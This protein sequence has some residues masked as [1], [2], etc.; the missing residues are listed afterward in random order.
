[1]YKVG[2]VSWIRNVVKLSFFVK[3]IEC[4]EYWKAGKEWY[5]YAKRVNKI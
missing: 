3:K 4:L 1:M 5:N 2:K